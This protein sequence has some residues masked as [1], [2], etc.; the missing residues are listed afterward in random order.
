MKIVASIA[1]ALTT[2][3]ATKVDLQPAASYCRS[4]LAIIKVSLSLS[5]TIWSTIS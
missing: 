3:F 1:R 2:L 5:R 4:T